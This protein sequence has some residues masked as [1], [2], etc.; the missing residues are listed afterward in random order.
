MA[1]YSK[2]LDSKTVEILNNYVSSFTANSQKNYI[3]SISDCCNF[4]E[5]D[6]LLINKEDA[7]KYA[8]HLHQ[9]NKAEELSLTTIKN[10]L[11]QCRLFSDYIAGH[12]KSD[13]ICPFDQSLEPTKTNDVKINSIPTYE[14][15]D[16][17]LKAAKKFSNGLFVIVSMVARMAL[18]SSAIL[19][20]NKNDIFLSDDESYM[21][22][23]GTSRKKD[24]SVVI[25]EDIKSLIEKYLETCPYDTSKHLFFNKRGKAL[26]LRMLDFYI[27]TAQRKANLKKSFCIRNI[28]DRAMLDMIT[29]GAS[30]A[31]V[32]K[33]TGITPN[34]VELYS[35]IRTK[36]CPPNLTH[37]R[38]VD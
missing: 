37:I 21:V 27:D 33:Y 24:R 34:R 16:E 3:Y 29:N 13:F 20:L 9:K 8:E 25:P 14:E 28:K 38:I 19:K 30:V 31:D 15:L 1:L 7:Y 32:S 23:R 22:I 12:V 10:I 4:L 36:N 35:G 5:K 2:Y 18:P 17:V 26:S 6:F 11:S